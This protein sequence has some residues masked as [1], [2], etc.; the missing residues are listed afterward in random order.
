MDESKGKM[1]ATRND[2]AKLGR[3]L[4]GRMDKRFDRVDERFEG[5]DKRITDSTHRLGKAI[6]KVH[7]GLAKLT[8][9]FNERVGKV[10]TSEEF[11]ARMDK[12]VADREIRDRSHEL[13]WDMLRKCERRITVLE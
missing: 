12:E 9:Q 6:E 3:T 10:M 13:R 1:P 4:I 5:V 8:E 7:N 2:L 11:H